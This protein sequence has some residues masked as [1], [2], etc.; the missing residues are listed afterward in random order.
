MELKNVTLE[1]DRALF[2]EAV[3]T[4]G[5]KHL[6]ELAEMA[7]QGH[8]AVIFYCVQRQDVEEM[9]P[10]GCIDL[11]SPNRS[12]VDAARVSPMPLSTGARRP[13]AWTI[14]SSAWMMRV[15]SYST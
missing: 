13:E 4:Q 14:R 5:A 11:D 10:A 7:R 2:P 3:T 15:S 1:A 9:G 12:L 8:R 6:R